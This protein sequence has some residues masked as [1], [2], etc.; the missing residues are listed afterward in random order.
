MSDYLTFSTVSAAVAAVSAIFVLRQ[1]IPIVIHRLFSPLR[2]LPGPPNDHWFYGHAQAIVKA[3]N[4][5]LQEAWIQQYGP[6]IS[7]QGLVGVR[8]ARHMR[9]PD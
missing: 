1:L 3:E 4:S 2:A 5:A 7:Y 6:T 8:V 9:N